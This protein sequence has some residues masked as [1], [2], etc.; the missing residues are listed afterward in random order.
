[1]QFFNR[2]MADETRASR[3]GFKGGNW[4]EGGRTYVRKRRGVEQFD[5]KGR[6]VGKG[7][8]ACCYF[9]FGLL[10]LLV[11]GYWANHEY[12]QYQLSK[13]ADIV[14]SEARPYN[15]VK[16]ELSS[17]KLVLFNFDRPMIQPDEATLSD[18]LFGMS[19]PG[20]LS[21]QRQAEYCQW[22]ETPHTHSRVVGQRFVGC[23][24][25]G[26]DSC[27]NARCS[28]HGS[29]SSCRS[30]PC[31]RANIQVDKEHYKT[32][33]YHKAW[34][35]RRISSLL[36]DNA[37]SYH[38]PQ[39][40]PAPTRTHR[41]ADLSGARVVFNA[42][43]SDGRGGGGRREAEDPQ[44]P[45]PTGDRFTVRP[46]DLESG[47]GSAELG[48]WTQPRHISQRDLD[49]MP[50][51]QA[52]ASGF[53]EADGRYFYSR[54]DENGVLMGLG[55]VAASYLM[56]NVV[57]VSSIFKGT[58]TAGDVRVSFNQALIPRSLSIVATAT[59]DGQLS[60]FLYGSSPVFLARRG[61]FP[62]TDL[63]VKEVQDQIW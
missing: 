35:T 4:G 49:S 11:L 63:F 29:E 21:V 53:S 7:E 6:V 48:K 25:K 42:V 60:P 3:P 20:A 18:P 5:S 22:Q 55:K 44:A 61:R 52:Q 39:R 37:I 14:S 40:D 19:F 57:D 9:V 12:G 58:C 1:M 30:D 17:D 41:L 28:G 10:S 38:N 33:T 24:R 31:C 15:G 8:V 32:Y 54:V 26:G 56:E 16:A 46:A 13:T 27:Q 43:G 62:T 36:F 34:R 45:T 47:A 59:S 51:A 23:S 50:R 2:W